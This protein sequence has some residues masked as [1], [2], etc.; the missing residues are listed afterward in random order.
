LELAMTQIVTF[1][2]KIRFAES[3]LNHLKLPQKESFLNFDP[4][5][6]IINRIESV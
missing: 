1:D 2:W 5:N 4:K 3:F 6:D